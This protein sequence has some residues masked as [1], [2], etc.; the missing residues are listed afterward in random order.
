MRA[1]AE[2]K[3]I[4]IF[5]APAKEIVVNPEEIFAI[6]RHAEIEQT[7]AAAAFEVLSGRVGQ[8]KGSVHSRR[9]LVREMLGYGRHALAI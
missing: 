8:D 2:R 4:E 5:A 3:A 1:D 9:T 6:R 7:A